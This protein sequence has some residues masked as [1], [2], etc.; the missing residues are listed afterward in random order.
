[1][2]MYMPI[3]MSF[4]DY[5]YHNRVGNNHTGYMALEFLLEACHNPIKVLN[6]G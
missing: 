3:N 1:M 4:S 5:S 6:Y 2:N